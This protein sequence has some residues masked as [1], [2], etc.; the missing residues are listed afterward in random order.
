MGGVEGGR[1]SGEDGGQ[2]G[3]L[4]GIHSKAGVA[5]LEKGR[6]P[7]GRGSVRAESKQGAQAKGTSSP[8]RAQ[9]LRNALRAGL[10]MESSGSVPWLRST[11]EEGRRSR[12]RKM[13]GEEL[14]ADA[15][16]ALTTVEARAGARVG[17][18]DL[19]LSARAKE[20][21]SRRGS[22]RGGC[23]APWEREEIPS[24]LSCGRRRSST[25][26]M[27]GRKRKGG[28]WLI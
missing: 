17:H 8:A 14:G 26:E 15:P 10:E 1:R 18:G 21:P 12:G 9:T 25:G 4:D 2:V 23:V 16:T 3:L 24:L 6:K 20:G 13:A 28:G 22:C 19:L 27:A 7:D 5:G 11:L